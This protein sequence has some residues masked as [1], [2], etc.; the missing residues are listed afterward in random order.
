[1]DV[2]AMAVE[3]IIAYS[4]NNRVHNAE[5]IDRIA[6]S[7]QQFGFNQPLVVDENN[8][9]LVGHG[10]WE[11]AKKLGMQ[12]VPVTIKRDLTDEQKRAYRIIDN[13]LQGDSTWNWESLASELDHLKSQEWDI[14]AFGLETLTAW[15]EQE[16][17]EDVDNLSEKKDGYDTASIKQIVLYF[18]SATYA[19]VLKQL[20][21]IQK[22][23][24]D[25]TDNSSAVQF[26]L[27]M[28]KQHEA[29]NHADD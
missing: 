3:S 5:Q 20:L 12:Q 27:G 15:M 9:I 23:V 16:R 28:W 11:A 22:S 21:A 17:A 25:V 10:R 26:L 13:K 7:I 14:E 18:D 19:D 4:L 2:Q 1:M 29:D 6:N 24:P 8:I